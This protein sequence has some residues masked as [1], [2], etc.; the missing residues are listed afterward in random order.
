M[1]GPLGTVPSDWKVTGD[2]S[3][4]FPMLV[5]PMGRMGVTIRLRM[6]KRTTLAN[7]AN[8]PEANFRVQIHHFH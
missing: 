4:V 8:D 6:F 2:W 3:P 7:L 5:T 1:K